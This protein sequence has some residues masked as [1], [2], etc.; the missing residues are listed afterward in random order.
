MRNFI[1][2]CVRMYCICVP[3]YMKFCSHGYNLNTAQI[4]KFM[5]PTW[6]PPGSCRS[7]MG[8]MLAPW[9]LLS[10]CPPIKCMANGAG[11]PASHVRHHIFLM[12]PLWW[13]VSIIYCRLTHDLKNKRAATWTTWLSIISSVPHCYRCAWS[14]NLNQLIIHANKKR[15]WL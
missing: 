10:G 5:G 14:V 1:Y 4:A 7:Q 8:P 2:L 9:T 15:L 12:K 11:L 6:G 3:V 13:S